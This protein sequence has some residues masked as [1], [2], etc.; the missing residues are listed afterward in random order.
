MDCKPYRDC[1]KSVFF[2][3]KLYVLHVLNHHYILKII[4]ELNDQIINLMVS[5]Q[6]EASLIASSEVSIVFPTFALHAILIQVLEI[7]DQPGFIQ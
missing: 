1:K 3:I 4:N 6:R 5:Q 7:I 2:T